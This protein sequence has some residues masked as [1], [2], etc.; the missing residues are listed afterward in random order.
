MVIT[1]KTL[2]LVR[3]WKYMG[4]PLDIEFET[5]NDAHVV[6]PIANPEL[7]FPVLTYDRN[8]LTVSS[9]EMPWWG[10]WKEVE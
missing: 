8:T 5:E 4:S 10:N 6:F 7:S 1:T 2:Y 3:R 9:K